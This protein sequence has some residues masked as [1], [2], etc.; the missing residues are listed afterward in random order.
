MENSAGFTIIELVI[1]I[2]ILSVAVIAVSSA[3][4]VMTIL[5]SDAAD[6]LTATY[7]AQEGMEIARNMRDENWLKMD[8]NP[9]GSTWDS[10]LDCANGCQ[11]DYKTGTND[12]LVMSPWSGSGTYL[13]IDPLNGFYNYT[14]GED[15][16]FKRKITIKSVPD[17]DN[18]SDHIVNVIVEVS[19]NS[20]SNLLYPGNSAGDC[21]EGVNCIK[22]EGE[23]YDWYNYKNQ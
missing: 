1:S 21:L 16:K 12:A 13:R 9:A 2:L 10:G 19:W 8:A 22:A 17:V 15:T 20:K 3:F 4:F 6:R 18:L 14:G 23:L 7:L 5:T 11:A